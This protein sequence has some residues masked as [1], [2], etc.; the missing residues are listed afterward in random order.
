MKPK[1]GIATGALPPS[2]DGCLDHWETA[3]CVWNDRCRRSR[4]VDPTNR[5]RGAQTITFWNKWKICSGSDGRE[6]MD[7]EDSDPCH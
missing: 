1:P 6:V 3:D 7:P 4:T 5:L 2:F